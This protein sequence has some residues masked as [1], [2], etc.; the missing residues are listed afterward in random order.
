MKGTALFLR[1]VLPGQMGTRFSERLSH[2][3]A[4]TQQMPGWDYKQTIKP[5][6]SPLQKGP[7]TS[8]VAQTGVFSKQLT[9]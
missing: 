6:L 2:C 3:P 1:E 5:D 9:Q 4:S 8:L 7:T